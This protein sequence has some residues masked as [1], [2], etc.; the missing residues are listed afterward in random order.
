LLL[1]LFHDTLAF[2]CC[3]P[4]S[5]GED[6]MRHANAWDDAALLKRHFFVGECREQREE[7]ASGMSAE[8]GA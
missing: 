1:A 6:A 8:R 2:N 5:E 7:K 3:L 4:L